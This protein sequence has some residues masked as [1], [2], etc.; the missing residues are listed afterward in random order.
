MLNSSR[1]MSVGAVAVI[2]LSIFAIT[3]P[4]AAAEPVRISNSFLQVGVSAKDGSVLELI[5]VQTKQNQIEQAENKFPVWELEIINVKYRTRVSSIHA[6]APPSP[7][8]C[9]ASQ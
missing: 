2:F 8:L 4:L 6:K 7:A 1:Q 5:D 3:S 9:I